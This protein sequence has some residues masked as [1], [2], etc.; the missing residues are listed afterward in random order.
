MKVKPKKQKARDATGVIE[1]SDLTSEERQ[2]F[3]TAY[4]TESA[5]DVRCASCLDSEDGKQAF[6]AAFIKV[7]EEATASIAEC[8]ELEQDKASTAQTRLKFERF[9]HAF[10]TTAGQAK[11][12]IQSVVWSCIKECDWQTLGWL[13]GYLKKLKTGRKALAHK[14]V[15]QDF[16]EM[17]ITLGCN[18]SG[19]IMRQFLEL[20][21][22]KSTFVL[23]AKIKEPRCLPTKAFLKEKVRIA[24]EKRGHKAD[25]IDSDFSANLASMGLGGL[26]AS[27]RNPAWRAKM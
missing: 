22:L 2:T 17:E 7:H 15:E 9:R 1:W 18:L 23:S 24:W 6:I 27:S 12:A 20:A 16:K 26:P 8:F 11:H 3:L 19:V 25:E 14:L 13:A 5:L 21:E 4:D 10:E